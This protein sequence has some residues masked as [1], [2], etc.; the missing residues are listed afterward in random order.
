M[1]LSVSEVIAV[2]RKFLREEAGYTN[3]RIGSVVGLEG[4]SCWKVII[5]IEQPS[6]DR[7]EIIV[8]DRDGKVISYKQA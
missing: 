6:S 7:K 5:V 4:E 3:V 8:D 1:R 2:T